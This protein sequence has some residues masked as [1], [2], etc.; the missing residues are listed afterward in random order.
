LFVGQVN[1]RKGVPYFLEMLR[2]LRPK[3]FEARLVGSIQLKSEVLARYSDLC[4]FTG[5]VPRAQ[6]PY[7]YAWADV[8][9]FP[10]L[11]DS[12]PGATNEA[13][14]AGLPIITTPGAGTAIEDGVEGWIV[15]NRDI[16]ALVNRIEQ[17]DADRKLLSQFS[18]NAVLKAKKID[19]AD[20]GKQLQQACEYL[21][22]NS[23]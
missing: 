8:F 14:A 20:Y 5:A 22:T 4:T 21:L 7:H 19:V 23:L 11:C 10:S 2:R 16:E 1:L 18:H 12:A 13:L 6:M 15:P 9:V 17:L 3:S